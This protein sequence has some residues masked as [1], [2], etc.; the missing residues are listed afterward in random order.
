MKYLLDT[1]VCVTYL[2]KLDSTVKRRLVSTPRWLVCVCSVVKSELFYGAM[3]SQKTE[4][5]LFK[6]QEF[7][8]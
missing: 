4:I 7:L 8:N 1:N 6:Q 5:T 2:N 3:K